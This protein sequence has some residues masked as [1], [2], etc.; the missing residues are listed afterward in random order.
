MMK[1]SQINGRDF[2]KEI[3]TKLNCRLVPNSGAGKTQKG[4]IKTNF[5]LLIVNTRR[6]NSTYLKV[7]CWIKLNKRLWQ[8]GAAQ[9]LF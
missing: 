2:E 5:S 9:L 3:A 6:Q 8:R 1:S 7:M 4:D